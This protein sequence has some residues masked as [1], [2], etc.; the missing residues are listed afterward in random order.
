MNYNESPINPNKSLQ[1]IETAVVELV[2]FNSGNQAAK[3][4]TF[5]CNEVPVAET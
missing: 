1:T 3:Y 5:S 2:Q 4:S